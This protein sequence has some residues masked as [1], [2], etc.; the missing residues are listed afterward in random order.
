MDKKLSS[1]NICR[2]GDNGAMKRFRRTLAM[3]ERTL[4]I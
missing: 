1:I 2:L 4:S 3:D